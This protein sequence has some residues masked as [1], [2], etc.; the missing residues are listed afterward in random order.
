MGGPTRAMSLIDK[1]RACRGIDVTEIAP[2]GTPPIVKGAS[3]L[4][5]FVDF[6]N[7]A[8]KGDA[9]L[10][11][12]HDPPIPEEVKEA[13]KSDEEKATGTKL[14]NEKTK[15]KPGALIV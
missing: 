5:E 11:Q 15:D 2:G 13:F 9:V 4:I 1:I 14:V 3:F 8:K 7:I 6:V 10:D 12:P